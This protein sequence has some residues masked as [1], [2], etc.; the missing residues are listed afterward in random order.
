[1][2]RP[3]HSSEPMTKTDDEG[4][5]R[6][7]DPG[8]TLRT[9]HDRIE[10]SL[11]R[12]VDFVKADDAGC[13]REEWTDLE[14]LVV[15]HMDAEEMFLL[16]Y[17]DQDRPVDCR[18]LRADHVDIRKRLGEIGLAFDLHTIRAEQVEEL[19]RF[20]TRHVNEENASLYLWIQ[21]TRGVPL[22][23]AGVRRIRENMITSEEN[24]AGAVLRSLIRVC[25]DGE[26]GYRD[27][28]SLSRDEG[29]R[30]LFDKYSEQ[31]ATFAEG[32]RAAQQKIG[33][34]GLVRGSLLGT[35]HRG[36]IDASAALAQRNTE[37]LLRECER[38]ELAALKVYRLA[39]HAGLPPQIQE[40]VE[41]QYGAVQ[42]ALAEVRS[43]IGVGRA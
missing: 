23:D 1:M 43:L 8:G 29:C 26:Q 22:V 40:E 24:T 2:T 5:G 4:D 25:L 27:A 17:F 15:R 3:S 13:A 10:R 6:K 28:S 38:G 7:S 37:T 19:A 42:S 31:R 32:L 18:H 21:S 11:R 34:G 36:W 9:D 20:L 16:P 33:A 35:I 14:E 30:I 39:M 41:D 12:I